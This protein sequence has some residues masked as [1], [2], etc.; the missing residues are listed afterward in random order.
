MHEKKPVLNKK[1][2]SKKS[3]QKGGK[4]PLQMKEASNVPSVTPPL[5][6]S[7]CSK[8]NNT[9]KNERPVS[10]SEVLQLKKTDNY[11]VLEYHIRRAALE[12]LPTEDVEN[13][14]KL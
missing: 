9:T 5:P 3:D 1:T 11:E 13:F 2:K 14:L 12:M 6:D 4:K 8:I 10:L 7:A